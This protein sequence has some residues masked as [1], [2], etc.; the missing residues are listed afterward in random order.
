MLS[1][2]SRSLAPSRALGLGSSRRPRPRPR[3]RLSID[4]PPTHLVSFLLCCRVRRRFRGF[5]L[6]SLA[7]AAFSG[8]RSETTVRA[9]EKLD[10]R[11]CSSVRSLVAARTPEG[12]RAGRMLDRRVALRAGHA[13]CPRAHSLLRLCGREAPAQHSAPFFPFV[14]HTTF[15][16]LAVQRTMR[17][18]EPNWWTSTGH[19]DRVIH[20]HKT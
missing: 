17:V 1:V 12:S 10:F 11:S 4:L 5:P 14:H 18:R 13:R 20:M 2:L 19:T 3:L 15:P 6:T 9:L 8:I 7:E 16:S